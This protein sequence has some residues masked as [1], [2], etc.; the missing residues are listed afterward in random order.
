[1]RIRT[2]GAWRTDTGCSPT[3]KLII[4]GEGA[5]YGI[6]DR[7]LVRRELGNCAAG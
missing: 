6:I 1:M 5:D 4:A 3:S 7:V 2:G